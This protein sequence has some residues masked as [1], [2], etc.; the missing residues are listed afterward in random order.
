MGLARTYVSER[1]PSCI[2]IASIYHRQNSM[3]HSYAFVLATGWLR[4]GIPTTFA[5][6]K[7]GVPRGQRART[8]LYSDG[9]LEDIFDMHTFS[10]LL[11]CVGFADFAYGYGSLAYSLLRYDR[12]N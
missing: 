6:T 4:Q 12:Q 9:S 5:E 8:H 3:I 2:N 7:K 10:R 1:A 11:C